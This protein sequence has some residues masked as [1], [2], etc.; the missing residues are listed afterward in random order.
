M[1]CAEFTSLITMTACF[2]SIIY[3]P[4]A[5]LVRIYSMCRKGWDKHIRSL[6]SRM[7]NVRM[8]QLE[9]NLSK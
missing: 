4:Y 2:F 5:F 8:A 1:H 6:L 7:G 9:M 3:C